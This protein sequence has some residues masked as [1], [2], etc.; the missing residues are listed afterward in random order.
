M[1][2]TAWLDRKR[3]F[4]IRIEPHR[5]IG[6]QRVPA[7]LA[8]D[9]PRGLGAAAITE[10]SRGATITG[11]RDVLVKGKPAPVGLLPQAPHLRP[12]K[13]ARR[14]VVADTHEPRR[15]HHE[16]LVGGATTRT[17]L[18]LNEPAR[19]E[20]A[21]RQLGSHVSRPARRPKGRLSLVQHARRVVPVEG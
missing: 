6:H 5:I 20:A 16:E 13:E 17:H 21:P 14:R 8:G 4:E 10:V 3:A 7:G 19:V 1:A 12:M 15:V 18:Q 11:R 2:P 9:H